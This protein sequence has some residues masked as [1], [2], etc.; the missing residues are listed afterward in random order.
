MSHKSKYEQL[1]KDILF[2]QGQLDMVISKIKKIQ[3]NITEVNIAALATYLLNFYNGIENIMER[4]AKEYY[5]KMPKGDD[6]HKQLLQQ[7][8][9]Q[10]KD[11]LPLFNKAIVD[12]LY[13]YL[14]FRH[15][16]IHGYGFKLNWDKMKSLVDNIDGLWREVKN[17]IA[18]FITEI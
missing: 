3:D 18:E 4:C 9:T 14:I 15:F 12:R 10:N 6:W 8:L 13:N 5:K 16:F 17:R 7:S 1:K 11:K 2:E